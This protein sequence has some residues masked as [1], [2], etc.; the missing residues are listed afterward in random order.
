MIIDKKNQL[1]RYKELYIFSVGIDDTLT[2]LNDIQ[3]ELEVE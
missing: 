1:Q 2:W 3:K